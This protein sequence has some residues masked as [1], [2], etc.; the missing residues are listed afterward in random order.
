VRLYVAQFPD[1]YTIHRVFGRAAGGAPDQLLH[2]FSG[3]TR[4]GDVLE[5]AP[6]AAWKD[7]RFVRVETVSSPSSAAWREIE[8]VSTG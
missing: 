7:V 1:G 4:S 6:P 2:E 3:F 8:L 5:Y